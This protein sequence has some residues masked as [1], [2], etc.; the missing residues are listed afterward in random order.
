MG[1]YKVT[2]EIEA[3]SFV[4]AMELGRDRVLGES[5]VFAIEPVREAPGA[6]VTIARMSWS[7][8]VPSDR[9]TSGGRELNLTFDAA[10]NRMV[11]TIYDPNQEPQCQTIYIAPE[12]AAVVVRA[13]RLWP[14]DLIDAIAQAE[15]N[16]RGRRT[17]LVK[18]RGDATSHADRVLHA[19]VQTVDRIR[20][21]DEIGGDGG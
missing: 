1:K 8:N 4:E 14:V 3:A 9:R 5:P 16:E 19:G 17:R 7:V 21:D 15:E 12:H 10:R 20:L 6:S 18:L 2:F 11:A 13:V